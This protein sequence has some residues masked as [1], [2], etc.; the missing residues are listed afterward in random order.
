MKRILSL[1]ATLSA[2]VITVSAQTTAC[3]NGFSM[4]LGDCVCG[5]WGEGQGLRVVGKG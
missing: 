3:V 4:V 1:I 2:F 5:P